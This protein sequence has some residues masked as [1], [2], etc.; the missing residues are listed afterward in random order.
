M[1]KIITLLF[2][3]LFLFC[4]LQAQPDGRRTIRFNDG[5]KFKLDDQHGFESQLYNDGDWRDVKLPHD[6]S[7]GGEFDKDALGQ[8]YLPT[9]IGW[10]RKKFTLPESDRNE[11]V[12]IQF[13]GV[14]M[15]SE[16]WVNGHLLGRYP[17]GYSTFVY[18]ITEF[19][20]FSDT[21]QNLV[22]VKVD[23]SLQP[24][25]RWYSGSGIY[26]N[27]W[28]ILTGQVHVGQ[29]GVTL[30]SEQLS[31][32][33]AGID[34]STKI[35]A[36]KYPETVYCWWDWDTT[37][38]NMV[39]KEVTLVT[40]I[41]DKN[42]EVVGKASSISKMENFS[43]ITIGQNI[44]IDNPELWTPETP[45]MYRVH[46]MIYVNGK[47]TDDLYNPLGIRYIEYSADN[48]MT[49]NG[50]PYKMKGVCLHHDGGAVGAAVPVELWRQ[51]LLLLREAGCNAIRTS[52]NPADPVFYDLCDSLGF[53]VLNEAFDEW[54][55]SWEL[56]QGESPTGKIEYGYH[57]YFSQWFET[58]LRNF[59][60]RDKN[61]PS[62]VMWS[63]G[64]E[65]PEQYYPDGTYYLKR[66][67]GI[68]HE[69]DPGRPVT[70]AT[71]GN[72]PLEMDPGFIELPDVGGF[73]YIVSKNGDKM[74]ENWHTRL[75]GKPLLGTETTNYLNDWT[76]VRDSKFVLGQFLWVGIDYL[77]EASWPQRGWN[78]SLIT[79]SGT[80]RDEFY[81]RK[82]LWSSDPTVYLTVDTFPD[83][84]RTWWD[85]PKTVSHWNWEKG[86]TR[87]VKCYTNCDV[88]E[89]VLNGKSLGK[90]TTEK[91]LYF[92]VWEV[93]FEP[94][95]LMV[96]GY[97]NHKK[98]ASYELKTAG[99]AAAL[100]V[101]TSKTK[102]R[103][104]GD[105][106]A[107]L[108]ISVVDR[109]GV[110]VPGAA[111][112][113]SVTVTGPAALIG[114][115]NGDQTCHER[116]K[117]STHSVYEGRLT[118]IVQSG[119]QCG[120]A[121]VILSAEGF[122]PVEILLTIEQRMTSEKNDLEN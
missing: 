120:N 25:S 38:R 81:Y 51:R 30:T 112:P 88:T 71:E 44:N 14:Y 74:Y 36:N 102:L 93:P 122:K 69:E 116:F 106:V 5:W 50:R 4:L 54:T 96:T 117:G 83:F 75:P 56:G 114:L 47:L 72:I 57:K 21:I 92:S 63:V 68:C 41:L 70:E 61:H 100:A 59:I 2:T 97:N 28:L 115:D 121:K 110:L 101:K 91:N 17:Y 104:D 10:Y 26:R 40:Q 20:K 24:S 33:R 42:G 31:E 105:D 37:R 48:G 107:L 118:A 23:N 84:K 6:W 82:C 62:V 3:N 55:R 13:D 43:E 89:L 67:I 9:G 113:V 80:P 99:H 52:H 27:V 58:D 29:W 22:A 60:R 90:K 45:F 65:I 86:S 76:A 87:I 85:L 32:N 79:T 78:R 64:N 98:V 66:M 16:V 77:G 1:R 94:G 111:S 95:E 46:S 8:G 35:I 49:I 108:E 12:F 39:A 15:N 11:K 18:D 34:I 119:N 19:V 73:N 7:I 103:A 53:L 109:N